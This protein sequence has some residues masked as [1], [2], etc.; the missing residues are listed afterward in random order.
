[1]RLASSSRSNRIR[2]VLELLAD[3]CDARL[4]LRIG[5]IPHAGLADAPADD[6]V[7]TAEGDPVDAAGA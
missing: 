4:H 7:T 1:M 5:Q 2:A 3:L 6:N